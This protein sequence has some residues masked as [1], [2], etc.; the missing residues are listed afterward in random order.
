M[1]VTRAGW[2]TLVGGLALLA[3]GRLLGLV[4]L[5]VLGVGVLALVVAAVV[6]VLTRRLRLEVSRVVSPARVH[7][8]SS[9][10][11]EVTATNR[12][13]RRTPVLRLRDPVSGTR[14]ANLL[15]APLDPGARATASYRLPTSRRGIVALGPLGVEISDPFG[16]AS[17][18]TAAT[19]AGARTELTV[20]PRIDE[21]APPPETRALDP[22]AGRLRTS[23]SSQNGE[24]FHALRLYVPGDDLRRVHW[25]ATAHHDDLLVRQDELP[26]QARTTV[27]LDTRR[28]AHTDAS[29]ELAV[30]AAASVV[31]AAW[32]RRD[33]VRL[34]TTDGIDLGFAAGQEHAD[35]IAEH[36]ATVTTSGRGSLRRSLDV[37]RRSAHGG[38]LV[39]VLAKV[40]RSDLE[41]VAHLRRTYGLVTTVVFE[42]SAWEPAAREP[43]PPPGP[44]EV[45][46][47]TPSGFAAAWA[48]A[49]LGPAPAVR[50]PAGRAGRVS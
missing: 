29:F 20:L 8:G 6:A 28:A 23:S 9:A 24:E 27:L 2:L 11:V 45:R 31:A 19:G 18:R 47:A 5:Y 7:A 12:G 32:R 37:L 35:A 13:R 48:A 16:L 46:V 44:H 10:R 33:L 26:W 30:S 43:A 50:V 21:V 14:G 36:L 22:H 1:R 17:T 3:A 42:P 49:R 4:E 41:A 40:P 25:R 34:V 38:A 39:A 15:L